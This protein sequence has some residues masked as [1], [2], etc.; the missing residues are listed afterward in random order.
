MNAR[1]QVTSG[2]YGSNLNTTFGFDTYGYPASTVTGTI[3]NFSYNFDPVS[4]NLNWWQNSNYSSLREDFYYDDLDRL[5]SVMR[6]NIKILDI[7][8]DSNKGGIVSKSDVGTLIYERPDKPYSVTGIDP[9]T[10]LVPSAEQVISYTSFESVSTIDEDNFSASLLYGFDNERS[11]MVITEGSNTILTRWY[12]TANYIKETAGS[13]TKEYTFI[14]G[15]PYTAPVVAITQEE[16]TVYYNLLRDYLGNITHVVNAETNQVIA[17]YSYDAWGRMRN[18]S[19]WENYDPGSEPDLIIAGR[20]FTGHEHLPWF[21]LINMNGRV[22][23]PLLA[24]FLSPD[25]FIHNPDRTQGFNRYVYCLGN[26]LSYTD[27]GGENPIL[28]ALAL[29]VGN[30]VISMLDNMINNDMDFNDALANANYTTSFTG[31]F[32]SPKTSVSQAYYSNTTQQVSLTELENFGFND[33]SMDLDFGTIT[34]SVDYLGIAESNRISFDELWNNYPS[35]PIVHT[36]KNGEDI[37]SEHCAINLS[38]AFMK[39]GISLSGGIRCWGNCASGG[40]H[41]IRAQ[42]L[43]NALSIKYPTIKL[44]GSNYIDYIS[45]KQ[46]IIFFKDYWSRT[47]E[48][49]RTGD[50]IDLWNGSY[51]KSNG[52]FSTRLRL[53][54]PNFMEFFGLSS[55]YRS[56]SVWFW[57]F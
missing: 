14:G 17:E 56:K 47:G 54:F 55:L 9:S 28:A 22:Y 24:M 48:N 6:N 36:D 38:E 11:K 32:N 52:W 12:P 15:D 20:G 1:Q 27:P 45:G 18:P 30:F 10:G 34:A 57:E 16:T 46:G 19:T 43:A 51:L 31:N 29:L 44:T 42:E 21:N 25:N 2:R 39:S 4:G 53:S 33:Y 8:F 13:T 23:D 26:P 49:G 40:G 35:T 50:H 5:D 7:D 37:F 41:F 3:Q